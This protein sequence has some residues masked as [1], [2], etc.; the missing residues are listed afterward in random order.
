MA[1]NDENQRLIQS[2]DQDARFGAAASTGNRLREGE[3]Y[4]HSG[5]APAGGLLL[6]YLL[7][8]PISG[9][10]GVA[11]CF[12]VTH[13]ELMLVEI[14]FVFVFA[15]AIGLPIGLIAK[16]FKVRSDGHVLLVVFIAATCGL[17]CCWAAHPYLALGKE[18]RFVAWTPMQIYQW[19]VLLFTKGGQYSGWFAL[20]VWV[21]EAGVVYLMSLGFAFVQVD[22]PFCED[23]ECW[24][25]KRENV[26]TFAHPGDPSRLAK[27]LQQ[28]EY[29][30]L[31]ECDPTTGKANYYLRVDMDMCPR[32]LQTCVISC[33]HVS[34]TINNKGEK[35][36]KELPVFAGIVIDPEH[37]Q[38]IIAAGQF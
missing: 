21:L 37:M 7:G 2:A 24:T 34:N 16:S 26:A 10:A 38:D 36:Q 15:A 11:Y 3:K 31:L 19:A 27:R 4:Q 30:A 1:S 35:E 22:Q 6:A 12:G 25:E 14:V 18:H 20:I 13:L 28:G 8:I 17:Y 5:I 32:C 23:C 9:L 33:K 29:L